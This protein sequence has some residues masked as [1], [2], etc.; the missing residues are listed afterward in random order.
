MPVP[1]EYQ[2]IHDH[3][4]K[5]LEDARDI[6]DIETTHRSYTMTQGVF[7]VFRR[8]LDLKDAIRFSNILPAGIRAL[9]VAD[10]NVEEP[11]LDFGDRTLMTEE[12][13]SLRA[14]H[15]FAPHTAI[16]DVARALR[17]NV[18]EDLLDQLLESLPRGAKQFWEPSPSVA[19]KLDSV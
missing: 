6:S 10:W 15:N 8:R 13:Q 19:R 17:M 18:D 3:L 2:R 9:F 12:V 7:Q 4:Y 11:K 16:E 5:F 1:A 14:D